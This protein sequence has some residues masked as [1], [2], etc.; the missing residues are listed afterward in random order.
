MSDPE[1]TA[2]INFTTAI[3]G[4]ITA[5]ILFLRVLIPGIKKGVQ[6]YT[7]F[8][9][10]NAIS[11]IKELLYGLLPL[12]GLGLIYFE[13]APTF[14][15]ICM[16]VYLAVNC[17]LFLNDE[18]PPTRSNIIIHVAIPIAMTL[19]SFLLFIMLVQGD[20]LENQRRLSDDNQSKTNKETNTPSELGEP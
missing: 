12:V 3:L 17:H 13:L 19:S 20:M 14:G 16:F 18:D 4:L 8:T 7:N 1:T 5:V 11:L 6:W 15:I 9:G 10:K 2:Y